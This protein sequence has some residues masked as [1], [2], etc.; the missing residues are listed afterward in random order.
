MKKNPVLI[1]EH[2]TQGLRPI[3][4]ELIKKKEYLLGGI[5]TEFGIL[6]RNERIYTADKFLPHMQ[7][8]LERKKTLGVVYGE[9]DHPDVFDTSLSRVSHTVE[10][11][12]Y[13]KEKNRVEGEIKLLSTHWGKE[14]RSLIDDGC[15]I[16]VSSRAAGITES[17]GTVTVKKLFT[18]DAVADPGFSSARMELRSMNESLNFNENANF[19]IYN[20][21]DES[22]FNELL[23]ENK[24][25]EFVTKTQMIEYS[26]YLS[27]M[28][29]SISKTVNES[30]KSGEAT[31]EEILNMSEVLESFQEQQ[32]KVGE[33]LDYL[34]EKIQVLVTE[35]ATLKTT[36]DKLIKHSDYLSENLENSIKYGEYL[37][38]K[39]DETIDYSEYIAE[40]LDNN[41]EFSEYIAEHVDKNIKYSEYIAENLDKSIDYSEYVA[42]QLDSNIAYSE[43]IA[44]NLDNSIKYGEYIAEHIDNNIAYAEYI[45][46]HVDDSIAYSEYIVENLSDT[47]AYTRYIAESLDK[48]ID[49]VNGSKIFESTGTKIGFLAE[50]I[51]QYYD[52]D[53]QGQDEDTI[54]S[55]VQTQVQP[56]VQ[57]Q[58][59]PDVQTQVQPDVQAQVQPGVEIQQ[60]SEVVTGDEGTEVISDTEVVTSVEDTP[61]S[62]EEPS[63]EGGEILTPGQTVAVGNEPGTVMAFDPAQKIVV[64]QMS[65]TGEEVTVQQESVRI[66]GDKIFE[67]EEQ[68]TKH[69][70]ELI[71]ESKKRKVAEKQDPHF[72]QFLTESKK[73]IYFAL[74]PE[75]KEKVNLALNESGYYSEVEVISKMADA[76]TEKKSFETVLLE[77]IPS[78][79]QDVYE[80][81]DVKIKDSI[82]AQAK[83]YPNLDTTAKMESF[84]YSRKLD[85]YIQ[86]NETKK[87][88]TESKV[89]DNSSMSNEQLSN[90]LTALKSIE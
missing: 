48:T 34:A 68:L 20:L 79:L 22:K 15:P 44:E 12:I 55:Q 35:N 32:E 67:K 28:I 50:D 14:A 26:N 5:F 39:L 40:T 84:W 70:M 30:V 59:Q 46:E 56:G 4:E 76:L 63:M 81:L 87:L 85:R 43:Y 58:V 80:K 41:I 65:S 8:L 54:Q 18:Y 9:F 72:L 89:F 71:T 19:R 7:E 21:S 1:V 23:M 75:E 42:E 69:I 49:A 77:N 27:E 13:N 2:C 29:E 10:S 83:L 25:Q 37:A 73:K 66:I 45:A 6:N 57:T 11:V 86:V 16:F 78:E 24:N 90:F 82:L 53:E 60:D 61:L 31:P 74:T 3:N 47:K 33:Y 52:E 64:V 36:A 38:G 88:I 17:D 62:T 51:N